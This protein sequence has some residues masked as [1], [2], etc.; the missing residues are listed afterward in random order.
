MFDHL[1]KSG[2]MAEYI[3]N[4]EFAKDLEEVNRLSVQFGTAFDAFQK[5]WPLE[6]PRYWDTFHGEHLLCVRSYLTGD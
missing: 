5:K 2:N 3:Q 4:P 1:P 6:V